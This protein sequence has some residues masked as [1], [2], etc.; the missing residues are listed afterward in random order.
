MTTIL[1]LNHIVP[2]FLLIRGLD[3]HSFVP[4]VLISFKLDHNLLVLL[5]LFQLS[6]CMIVHFNLLVLVLDHLFTISHRVWDI[7]WQEKSLPASCCWEAQLDSF[8]PALIGVDLYAN[9]A[10]CWSW[11]EA[12]AFLMI[13]FTVRTFALKK[14][15]DCG[16]L[17]DR[18][19]MF[20]PNF[21]TKSWNS[22]LVNWGCW[23][24]NTT[25]GTRL[26]LKIIIVG[27]I[28]Y[29]ELE[30]VI[31]LQ[32]SWNIKLLG[33]IIHLC[34]WDHLQPSQMVLMVP[35]D[36]WVVLSAVC[37][38]Q[39]HRW[40]THEPAAIHFPWCLFGQ[41][42]AAL[43]SKSQCSAMRLSFP[44]KYPNLMSYHASLSNNIC[45]FGLV[46]A[47]GFFLINSCSLW[48]V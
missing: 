3:H 11:P 31:F 42:T 33:E 29:L 32:N 13:F 4:F 28:T 43:L 8:T 25:A 5:Q 6:Y 10:R 23:S 16:Y 36:R 38:F 22:L 2:W 24:L 37:L 44:F 35:H 47:T 41:Y 39:Q 17:T 14:P 19:L 26:P 18:C 45:T 34:L 12:S 30:L 48:W 7:H 15:F 21:C 40:Y 1:S 27:A 9:M 46:W 20:K